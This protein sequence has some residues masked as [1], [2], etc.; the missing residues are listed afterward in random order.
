MSRDCKIPQ[1][2]LIHRTELEISISLLRYQNI[3]LPPERTLSTLN[4]R[5]LPKLLQRNDGAKESEEDR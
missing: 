1:R 3:E 2:T 4:C 5:G